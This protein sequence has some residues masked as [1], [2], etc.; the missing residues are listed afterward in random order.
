MK[1]FSSFKVNRCQAIITDSVSRSEKNHLD[2][3]DSFVHTF[4]FSRFFFF[5]IRFDFFPVIF[6]SFPHDCLILTREFYTRL[7]H[8]EF[9][10]D[11]FDSFSHVILF[12]CEFRERRA[13]LLFRV[14]FFFFFTCKR[15]GDVWCFPCSFFSPPLTLLF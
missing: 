3:F 8:F 9:K 11:S 15:S 4:K 12:T 10:R 13:G 5:V 2:S 1:T 14:T 6:F 7:T